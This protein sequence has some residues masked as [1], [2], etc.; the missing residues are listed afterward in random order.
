M[1]TLQ[2]FSS[3]PLEMHVVHFKNKYLTLEMALHDKDGV[4][5]IVYLFEVRIVI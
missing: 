2:F 5:I 3:Y 4:V 1:L